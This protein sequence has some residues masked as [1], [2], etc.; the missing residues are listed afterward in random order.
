V[1]I[2]TTGALIGVEKR[3]DINTTG[4]FKWADSRVELKNHTYGKTEKNG[5]GFL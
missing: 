4:K 3:V 5:E 1:D 2:N